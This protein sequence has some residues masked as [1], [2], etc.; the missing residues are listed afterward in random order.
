VNKSNQAKA[1]DLNAG[2]VRVES[3]PLKMRKCIIRGTPFLVDR[4]LLVAFFYRSV[5]EGTPVCAMIRKRFAI[6]A[7]ILLVQCFVLRVVL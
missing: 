4:I 3:C 6:S 7:G 5:V 2:C 1:H